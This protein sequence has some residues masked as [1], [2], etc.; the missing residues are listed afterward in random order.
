L[1]NNSEISGQGKWGFVREPYTVQ[2]GCDIFLLCAEAFSSLLK[3]GERD[4]YL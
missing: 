3:K 4:G 1:L 2:G